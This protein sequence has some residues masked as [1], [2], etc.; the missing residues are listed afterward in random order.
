MEHATQIDGTRHPNRPACGER[1]DTVHSGDDFRHGPCTS[2][3]P[4]PAE[5]SPPPDLQE[6]DADRQAAVDEYTDCLDQRIADDL[7]LTG[8]AF[9]PTT[10]VAGW[11]VQRLS[12][13]SPRTGQ[14]AVDRTFEALRQHGD[15]IADEEGDR[16]A[17]LAGG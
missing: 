12:I 4:G 9:V 3:R 7:R 17:E 5:P 2:S 11:T 10:A 16:L 14:E 1:E 15:R 6:L 8:E 13:C